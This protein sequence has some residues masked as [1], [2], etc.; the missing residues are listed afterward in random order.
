M[1]LRQVPGQP[2]QV[3]VQPPQVQGLEQLPLP[4]V[5]QQSPL[6]LGP[7]LLLLWGAQEWVASLQARLWVVLLLQQLERPQSL[8]V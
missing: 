7:G 2:P 8:L 1:G 3:P 5:R 6:V 4:L